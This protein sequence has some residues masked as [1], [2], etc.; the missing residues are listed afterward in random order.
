LDFINIIIGTWNNWFE[1]LFQTIIADC[2]FKKG[3]EVICIEKGTEFQINDQC[4]VYVFLATD[5][6]SFS[7][8]KY[9]MIDF[10]H[11]LFPLNKWWGQG[12]AFCMTKGILRYSGVSTFVTRG[13]ER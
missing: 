2:P 13:S 9:Q 4:A 8:L 5:A 3:H 12:F 7:Y 10:F 11:R 6:N 1:L